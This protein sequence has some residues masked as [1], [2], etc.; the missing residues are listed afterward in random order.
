ME[1]PEKHVYSKQMSEHLELRGGLWG[2]RTALCLVLWYFFSF[3]TL[4]LNKYIMSFEGSDPTMLGS[5]QLL[6]CLVCGLFHLKVPVG[7]NSHVN[8]K[9]S[10]SQLRWSF[11]SRGLIFV[12]CL[13]FSTLFLGLVALWYVP[14]SFAET[15]K[16]SAPVF[17]VII[18]RIVLGEP[19]NL[20][21]NLSLIPV[22]IGLA[23]CSAYEM[24]FT[25][26]GFFASLATNVSE[27]LQNVCSKRLLSGERYEPHQIQFY[28]SAS[29]L[30]I[31]IPCILL[32]V[33]LPQFWEVMSRDSNLLMSFILNGIS[34]HCQS[35]TEYMLLQVISPVTHSVANTTKRALLIWA[36]V[37]VFGN[38]VTF[39]SWIGTAVVILGVLLY[40]KARQVTEKG[41]ILMKDLASN[42][43]SHDV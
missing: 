38:P 26:I 19:T 14:V 29:S 17:T 8:A 11:F 36:S 33:D 10:S 6:M 13:R 3:T 5:F 42:K 4:F 41:Y 43:E 35:M 12:G 39:Q 25:A 16:S 30:L 32:L 24:S 23:L 9:R 28:T 18:S 22:M 34:F 2:P 37:I 31:Q 27:C 40:N 21:V 1:K 20:L 7:M 15:V